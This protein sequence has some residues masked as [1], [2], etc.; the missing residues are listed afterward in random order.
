MDGKGSTD[1]SADRDR[2]SSPPS[3]TRRRRGLLVGLALMALLGLTAAWLFGELWPAS[4]GGG[5]SQPGEL[6]RYDRDRQPERR[7]PRG[8]VSDPLAE[9]GLKAIDDANDPLDPPGPLVRV[10]AMRSPGGARTFRYAGDLSMAEAAD[11]YLSALRK[12]GYRIVRDAAMRS[13]GRILVGE[14]AG[15]TL[16]VA[17]RN[18][19]GKSKIHVTV[20]A[21]EQSAAGRSR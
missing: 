10:F 5:N 16:E 4:R 20:I 12:I 8:L 2:A 9:V 7:N 11:H 3:T 18:R 17:L 19:D 1:V 14:K 21:R 6:L 13:G 15:D